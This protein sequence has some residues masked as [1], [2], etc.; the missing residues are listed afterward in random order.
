[1]WKRATRTLLAASLTALAAVAPARATAATSL[2]PLPTPADNPICNTARMYLEA[3]YL[4]RAQAIYVTVPVTADPTD[5]AR[6]GLKNIAEAR[7]EAADLVSDGQHAERSGDLK[8]AD[9]N[10]HNALKNDRSNAA[11][12]AGITQVAQLKGRAIPTASSKWDRF[13]DDWISPIGKLVLFIAI[14]LLV[15]LSASGLLSGAMVKVGAIEWS[16]SER[17]VAGGVGLALILGTAVLFPVYAMFKPFRSGNGLLCAAVIG[18][19]AITLFM[20]WMVRHVSVRLAK[21]VASRHRRQVWR[22]WLPLLCSLAGVILVAI[23]LS[24]TALTTKETRLMVAYAVLVLFGVLITAAVLGQRLQLQ[25][26]AQCADGV[27]HQAST[28]YLLARMQTLGT[29]SPKGLHVNSVLDTTPLSKLTSNELSALP[30]GS[31]AG[32]LSRIFFALNPGFTWRAR[33]TIVDD[34][35]VAISLSRNGRHAESTIF[36]RLDLGLPPIQADPSANTAAAPSEFD[37]S[38][39]R[40]RARAQLLTG[41]AA[42]VLLHLSRVHLSLAD[43][44]CGARNW[45]SVTLQLIATSKSLIDPRA[46]SIGLLSRAM[47]EDPGYAL[48]RFEYLWARYHDIPAET[49]DYRIFAESIER[50]YRDPHHG[51]KDEEGWVPLRIRVLYS[52][53]TQWL[54]Y[55]VENGKQDQPALQQAESAVRELLDVCEADHRAGQAALLAEQ[56]RPFA[57]NLEHSLLT[58][59]SKMGPPLLLHPHS[60]DPPSPKLT[61]DHACLDC[62]LLQV[63]RVGRASD[64]I[65]DLQFALATEPDRA[66]AR[67]DPCFSPI[68]SHD[69][70]RRLVH[71]NEFLDLSVF[72]PHKKLLESAGLT[73]S[74]ELACRTDDEAQRS[75]L[76]DYLKSSSVLVDQYRNLAL[77][78]QV[79]P[80]LEDP[81][82]LQIL[83]AG[84]VNSPEGLF[85]EAQRDPRKL[86]QAVHDAASRYGLTDLPGVNKPHSWLVNSGVSQRQALA[87]QVRQGIRNILTARP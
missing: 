14:G 87:A 80:N 27:V 53:A 41:A 57:Y 49:T 2:S 13:Y 70:F 11:A 37:T 32:V 25:V 69:S 16:K 86:I 40:D 22:D 35:R 18:V 46:Q 61:Y 29:E 4:D 48:A 78:A 10:F 33:T 34:N 85:Q 55:Y 77:L 39:A 64:A 12:A 83:L 67:N 72:L 62:F 84:G 51:V 58:L 81:R 52:I 23:L 82:M 42:F 74:R 20:L 28:D 7:Q 24:F 17:Y 60:E 21:D 43:H 56:M 45:K 76:A 8:T 9:Q 71:P 44:L 65:E 47:D 59:G 68:H 75:A 6:K 79:H 73:T 38:S 5:C 66:D 3:G 50:H 54:N 63:R 30:S 26:E 36:S 19:L 1:M 15:L 31:V